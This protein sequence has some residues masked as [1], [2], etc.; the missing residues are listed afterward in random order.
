MA[1]IKALA[2]IWQNGSLVD[3]DAA[4]VHVLSHGL[5]YGYSV[6]EGIRSFSTPRGPAVFRLDEH[7]ERFVNSARIYR[8][9]LPYSAKEL[10]TACVDLLQANGIAEAYLRPIAFSGYGQMGLDPSHCSIEVAIAAWE[11]GPYLGQQGVD[12]G[13]R[14]TV[15]SWARI[16]SRSMPPQAKCAANYANGA[17]AKMEATAGGY[18]EAILLNSAGM[19]AEGPGENIFKV[20]NDIVSTPPASSGILRGITRDSVIQFVKEE[21]LTFHRSDFTRE[22]LFTADE[23]FFAGT[24]VGITPIREIDGR[25]IGTGSYPITRRLQV[26]YDDAIHGRS[27][28]HADWLTWTRGDLGAPPRAP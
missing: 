27:A 1:G 17:L 6:F 10:R 4:R 14:A 23:L 15:S 25:P 2:K 16:D 9:A 12:H 5:H 24:A 19:V 7:L 3:W 18:D 8:M 11:W 22:D 20:K 21:G 28:Q 26:R 13:V